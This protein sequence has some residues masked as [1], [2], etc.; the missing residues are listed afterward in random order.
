MALPPGL[1]INPL[2]GQISG[3]PTTPGVYNFDLRV[4]DAQGN[5]RTVPASI[6]ILDYL[7]PTLAGALPQFATRGAPYSG[8]Y[9]V[10]GGTPPYAW[11]ISSGTLPTGITIDPDTGVISGTPTDTSYTDRT[12]TVRVVDAEGGPA[13]R[14]GTIRYADVLTLGGSYQN[15]VQGADFTLPLG[16]PGRVGGHSPFLFQVVAGSL[17]PGMTLNSSSGNLSGTPTTTG[18]SSFTLRVTDASGAT[19]QTNTSITVQSSY[20]PISISGSISDGAQNVETLSS[21]AATPDYSTLTISGGNTPRTFSWARI[22][23][24]TAISAG[25]PSSFQ[26]NFVGTIAPG[27]SLSATFRLT[28]SDGTSSAN[29]TVTIT[30]TNT[31][32]T[33]TLTGSPPTA[34]RTQAYSF[35]PSRGGGKSP[36]TFALVSGSL[37]S[38]LTLNSSTGAITGTPTSTTYGNFPITIRVTDALGG[39]ANLNATLVYQNVVTPVSISGSYPSA[40]MVSRS[41]SGSLTA[42][43]GAGGNV[44]SVFSGSLPPGLTL[45]TSTGALTGTPSANGSYSFTIRVTD[46]IGQTANSAQ[47]VTVAANLTIS[48]TLASAT[49]GVSYS[50]SLTASGGHG[51]NSWSIASGSLPAGLS[52]NSSTGAIAGTP[53]STGTSSFTVR[54][55]DGQ[56]FSAD[57]AQSITVGAAASVS[58]TDQLITD[59]VD[60]GSA[61]YLLQS[62]GEAFTQTTLS[63]GIR[64]PGEW[65]VAGSASQFEVRATVNF[66]TVT[67]TATGSWLSLGTTRNWVRNN[68]GDA[69][70]FVQI[71]SASTLTVL[72]SAT[73]D[74]SVGGV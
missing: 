44:W 64:I 20:T 28:V 73:V 52:I 34:T 24:S 38:G 43:G 63:G 53:S 39:V 17:P 37:P 2:T 59:P 33:L 14:T 41:Y 50:S 9:T 70:I 40:G 71:R 51:G 32:Q 74:L 60:G 61:G 29:T 3:V 23:G 68:N 15:A 36:Y 7:P 10:S 4:R 18:T 13:Q 12:I 21:F 1:A 67:G 27:Q 5:S 35:T 58:I 16:S 45:N 31:Y 25:S 30:L 49:Q 6:T 47:S 57:S 65:L 26:T 62:N 54:V 19:A 46:S 72:D 22:S 69:Q 56:G 48:G 55:T 8:L 11:S 66:G 42:S